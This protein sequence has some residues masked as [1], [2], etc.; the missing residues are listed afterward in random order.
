MSTRFALAEAAALAEAPAT[1]LAELPASA[2]KR[3]GWP[4]QTFQ[5]LRHRNYCLY[6]FGQLVSLTGSWLQTTALMWLAWTLTGSSRWT[7]LVGLGGILPSLPLAPLGGILAD[8]CSKRNL[9]FAT[10]ALLLVQS[11]ALAGLAWLG[12]LTPTLLLVC[13]L[14]AG[15]VNAVDVPARMAFVMDMVGRSDLVNAVG[16]NSLLFNVARVAGP[17]IG[18]LLLPLV[19]PALCFLLNSLTFVAV[20]AALAA[21]DPRRLTSHKGRPR[22]PTPLRAGLAEV[23]GN[24]ALV[25][26][27]SLTAVLSLCG[28]PAMVLLPALSDHFGVGPKGYGFLVSAV[29]GGALAAAF[30]VASFASLRR[31]YY[32]LVTGYVLAIAALVGLACAHTLAAALVGCAVLGA[33]LIL[34]FATSQAVTQLSASDHHRGAVMGI[35]AMLMSGSVPLGQ[36]LSGN[37]ADVWGLSTTFALEAV[38]VAGAAGGI[39]TMLILWKL[40]QRESDPRSALEPVHAE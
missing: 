29:G 32:F 11:L 28:W 18:A 27:L 4:G 13:S 37:A 22:H 38:G 16:L 2:P 10:Q 39:L 15:I 19:G 34:F 14:A 30:V 1:A 25:L 21:M 6:F 8:H 3:K 31:R 35:W 9:I 33:G 7:A 24:G 12:L 23:S 26:L 17:A 40:M 20:L 36:F 5:A